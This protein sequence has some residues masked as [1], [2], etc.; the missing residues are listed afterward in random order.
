MQ[1]P[2]HQRRAGA[3]DFELV[4]LQP[5]PGQ[6]QPSGQEPGVGSGFAAVVG[7][8]DDTRGREFLNAHSAVE[9]GTKPQLSAQMLNGYRHALMGDGEPFH[10]KW[11]GDRAA[12]AGRNQLHTAHA[13]GQRQRTL[14]AIGPR[15]QPPDR[16]EQHHQQ[17]GQQSQGAK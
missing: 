5:V 14:Q 8:H 13:V 2:Q 4:H 1:L 3:D 12:N 7:F 15:R 10:L 9:Q 16:G 11:P 6:T 17:Q